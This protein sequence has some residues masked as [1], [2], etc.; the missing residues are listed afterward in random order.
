LAGMWYSTR[1]QGVVGAGHA[2]PYAEAAYD[3]AR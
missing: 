3:A 1:G 2:R